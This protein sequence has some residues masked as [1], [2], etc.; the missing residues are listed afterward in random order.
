MASWLLKADRGLADFGLVR[1][2][3]LSTMPVNPHHRQ[4][5]AG[6]GVK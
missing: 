1:I 4:L 6:L 5:L 2:S 3:R